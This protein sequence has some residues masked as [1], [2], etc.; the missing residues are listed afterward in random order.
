MA[1]GKV[2]EEWEHD[3]RRQQGGGRVVVQLTLAAAVGRDGWESGSS[4]NWWQAGRGWENSS[5]TCAD[6]S[7]WGAGD[8][9]HDLHLWQAG[10]GGQ[11]HNLRRQESDGAT[12]IG[13]LGRVL[14]YDLC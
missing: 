8:Q 14:T 6:G 10:A 7:S 4:L 12:C 11:Q 1:T 2:A 13:R 9:Q 5:M 3:L